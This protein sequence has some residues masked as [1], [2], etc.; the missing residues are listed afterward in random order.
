[1]PAGDSTTKNGINAETAAPEA[2]VKEQPRAAAKDA[3]KA[4]A[5][6]VED[7]DEEDEEDEDFVRS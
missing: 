7:E 2:T 6:D 1:M 5:E 4:A 3:K